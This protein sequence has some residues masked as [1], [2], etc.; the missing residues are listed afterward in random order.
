MRKI[1]LITIIIILC[2]FIMPAKALAAED[3][4]L[5]INTDALR[6][7]RE[8]VEHRR[9]I[10]H[11]LAPTLFLCEM[12][13]RETNRRESESAW[14]AEI[15]ETLFLEEFP[16]NTFSTEEIMNNLFLEH[17]LESVRTLGG[18]P[19]DQVTTTI[20]IWAIAIFITLGLA[21]LVVGGVMFGTWFAK[22][23]SRKEAMA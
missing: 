9:A 14:F 10:G 17:P 3:G 16:P 7:T 20:P 18:A 6:D 21:V 5:E 12:T 13:E 23:K 1:I 4:Q 19:S 11:E 22:R 2:S 15:Q 8:D